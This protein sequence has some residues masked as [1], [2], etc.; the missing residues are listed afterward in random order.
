MKNMSR[1]HLMPARYL[2]ITSNDMRNKRLL[3][4]RACNRCQLYDR[5]ISNVLGISQAHGVGE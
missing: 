4:K 1:H 5:P 3:T 2:Y